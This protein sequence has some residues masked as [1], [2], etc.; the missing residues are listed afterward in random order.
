M[1]NVM[2]LAALLLVACPLAYGQAQPKAA[3]G[4]RGGLPPLIDREILIGNPEIASAQLSPDGKFIAFRKP[5][6]ETMNIWV[7]RADDPFERARLVTGET[8][9]PVSN[10]F[11]SRDGKFILFVKDNGGDENFNVY[12]VDPAAMPTAGA[13]APAARNLTNAQKVRTVIYAV[14]SR[15]RT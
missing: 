7:K 8:R 14:P 5:Y 10:F 6:K 15:S 2:R 11:W 1:K 4:Q 13:D 9:R 3:A 12:A